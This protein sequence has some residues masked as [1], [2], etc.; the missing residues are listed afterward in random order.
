M[1][2]V[3]AP[4]RRLRRLFVGRP[5]RTGQLEETLLPKTLAL[6]IFASDPLSSVAYATESALVVLLAVSAASAHLVFPISIAIAAAPRD[7]RRLVHADGARLRDERRRVHRRAREPRHAAEPR[8]RCGAPHRLRPH[9]RGLDLRRDLR[10]HVVRAVA[11]RAQGRALAR[12]PAADRARQPARRPRVGPRLRAA[13]LSLRH[14][15]R[16][17]RHRGR[18]RA[19]DGPC[20]SRGRAARAAGRD[21]RDHALRAPAR[22]L[23]RL[24]RADRRRGDRERRQRVPAPARQERGAD[25]RHPR[26]DRD[27]PLPRRL[28]PRGAPARAAELDC[29][30]PLA[31]R[32]RRVPGRVGRELHVLRRAGP[33]AARPDPR[34]EHVVPGLPAPLGAA[35]ARPLRAAAVH[36]PRRP[37]R[38]LE[39]DARARDRRR[40]C[41]SGSTARTRT[42]SSTST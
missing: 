7:R 9:R 15:G 16:R 14:R 40:A 37:A 5:M 36:E 11:V 18:H 28:V 2:E 17:A 41:C 23:V 33:D 13:D 26:L 21:R 30:G 24:D 20:A 34:R 4:P 35:R 39:R 29:V 25:A 8:R 31:D 12:L 42:T 38:V 32:A 6:P 27:L 19:R 22:V 1:T 3:L 10:G